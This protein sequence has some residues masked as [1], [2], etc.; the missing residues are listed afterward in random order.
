MCALH[1]THPSTHLE[2]WAVGEQSGV[3]CLAQG[4]H[5]SRGQLLPEPRFETT[6]SGYKS[7][8]L[9]TRLSVFCR[10]PPDPTLTGDKAL[11]VFCTGPDPTLTG[12]K[13]LS[14]FCTGPDPTL[15]GDKAL[16]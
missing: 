8:A 7:D 12:D 1:L 6:T 10:G 4:S 11:S 2:Q 14:V 16:S 15:T 5:L 13:A 9:S 3:R